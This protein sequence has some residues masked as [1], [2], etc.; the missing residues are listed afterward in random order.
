MDALA[1]MRV[2][3]CYDLFVSLTCNPR[4]QK[5]AENLKHGQHHT[6]RVFKAK[7][8]FFIEYL[9]QAKPFGII[10]YWTYVTEF[11]K[12][13]LKHAH[14]VVKL[15]DADRVDTVDAIYRNIRAEIPGEDEPVL[16]D[17]VLTFMIHN[18]CADDPNMSCRRRENRGRFFFPKAFQEETAYFGEN[19][20]PVYRRQNP[21]VI[22]RGMSVDNR[23]GVPYNPT[24]IMLM[25]C[26]IN[27][28]VQNP[29]MG[30]GY[31]Y[32]YLHKGV[33][34][35][36]VA[37]NVAEDGRAILVSHDEVTS[38]QQGRYISSSDAYW[39][40][41]CFPKYQNSH[42]FR[43]PIHLPGG[44][45]I[46]FEEGMEEEAIRREAT[47]HTKLTAFFR[48]NRVD[49]DASAY[50]YVQLPLYYT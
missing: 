20:S 35:E 50:T 42:V 44:Q 26:H 18:Q 9:I 41:A 3:V 47:R 38:Y 32:K 10:V 23:Y 43:L 5:I 36:T 22:V 28:E 2:F 12:M 4:W 34:H 25:K 45:T 48:L 6:D 1:G 16:R 17:L 14:I 37:F 13:G 30:V 49:R 46:L 31:L 29:G 21:P 15:A 8:D 11:Q 27:V 40:L 39:N 7:M 19:R 24:L 33:D